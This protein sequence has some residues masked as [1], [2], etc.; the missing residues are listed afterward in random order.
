[1]KSLDGK[2]QLSSD[3]NS[4]AMTSIEKELAKLRG[5]EVFKVKSMGS[6]RLYDLFST[7]NIAYFAWATCLHLFLFYVTPR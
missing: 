2:I 6:C 5:Q 4:P 7:V 3:F 1:M